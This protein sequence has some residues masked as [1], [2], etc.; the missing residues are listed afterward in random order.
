MFHM[1]RPV[2]KELEAVIWCAACGKE[3]YSLYRVPATGSG[4]FEHLAEP[5]A[6]QEAIAERRGRCACGAIVERK[7]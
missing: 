4:V 1:E 6:A 2:G 3:H 7:S 5:K